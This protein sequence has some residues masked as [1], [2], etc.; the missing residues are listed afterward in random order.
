MQQEGKKSVPPFPN[1]LDN[2]GVVWEV[3]PE[4]T[5]YGNGYTFL[6]PFLGEQKWERKYKNQQN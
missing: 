3:Y 6:L 1:P 5:P 2:E 4:N